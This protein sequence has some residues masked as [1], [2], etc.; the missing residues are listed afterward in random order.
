MALDNDYFLLYHGVQF[1]PDNTDEMVDIVYSPEAIAFYAIILM[2]GRKKF[3]KFQTLESFTQVCQALKVETPKDLSSLHFLQYQLI[4]TLQT[5]N[6]LDI[7]KVLQDTFSDLFHENVLK[8]ENYK[9]LRSLF[10]TTQS[11]ETV[12]ND[13]K[14]DF[15]FLIE[16]EKI[17]HYISELKSEFEDFAN[18]Q[19][20]EQIQTTLEAQTFSIGI[21]GVMNAGK[22][23]MINAL[24]GEEIL[25]SSVV[26]ET[27][28][29][30]LLTYNTKPQ[31]KV[32][33]WNAEEWSNIVDKLHLNLPR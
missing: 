12:D 20:L 28:N 26:P 9:K 6:N 10:E 4:Q 21:T 13:E 23:T 31:A 33:Y 1:S 11:T 16:K 22:S 30:T 18:V 3:E 14:K 5:H 29:L 25:G 8:K 27:A 2:I 15:S 24:L 32:Y 7:Y 17:S 19:S